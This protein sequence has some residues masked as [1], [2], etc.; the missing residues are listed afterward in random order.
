MTNSDQTS[1]YELVRQDPAAWYRLPQAILDDPQLK[2][3]E[4]RELLDE[5]LLDVADRAAAADEGMVPETA[6]LNDRDTRM[7]DHLVAAL[8]S[9]AA[10]TDDASNLSFAQR[11][12]RRIAAAVDGPGQSDDAL[13]RTT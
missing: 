6:A 8:A 13:N 7:Q 10:T 4:K 12:W 2:P 11:L 1:D 9:L 3:S 5:W